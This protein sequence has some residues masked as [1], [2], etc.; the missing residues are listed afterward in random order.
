[1]NPFA[2]LIGLLLPACG[3]P[4]A[5]GL[6][7]PPLT[8]L[9]Q[10]VRPDSPNTALAAPAGFSPSPDI[11]TP[12]YQVSA[13][14]LFALIREVAASQPRTY[15]AAVYPERLQADYVA[16]SLVFNFPDRV[17]VQVDRSDADRSFLIIYSRSVYG[18]SDFGVN[19]RRVE[20]WL[21]VLKAKIPLPIER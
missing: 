18:R 19:R 13:D 14:R 16:R 15:Q 1:M 21:A 17:V 2:W 10:I 9:G 8:D 6:P 3:L 20:T 7:T 4:A 12:P 11:V 5:Q